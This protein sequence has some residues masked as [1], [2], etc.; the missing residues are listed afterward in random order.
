MDGMQSTTP[1]I[2]RRVTPVS[3]RFVPAVLNWSLNDWAIGGSHAS[4]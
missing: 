1:H 3:Q 2:G 4:Y